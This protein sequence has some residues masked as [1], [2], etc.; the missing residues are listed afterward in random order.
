MHLSRVLMGIHD[1][2]G[3]FFGGFGTNG[4]YHNR[5][6]HHNIFIRFQIYRLINL[7]VC[8]ILD[9]SLIV[10]CEDWISDVQGSVEKH[11]FN[12]IMFDIAFSGR[13]ASERS[14]YFLYTYS[15]FVA[16]FYLWF[17]STKYH[18][19]IE[20]SPNYLFSDWSS[21][22]L[23]NSYYKEATGLSQTDLEKANVAFANQNRNART[24][25]AGARGA[26]MGG[27][28]MNYGT[29]NLKPG[30]ISKTSTVRVLQPGERLENTADTVVEGAL[31][32]PPQP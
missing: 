4:V 17:V 8:M 18:K 11:G 27:R 20:S 32:P 21:G 2:F 31:A 15:L 24:F 19:K 26:F 9:F 29:N 14:K 6:D 13:C 5:A 10:T 12:K 1:F 22:V 28:F 23:M 7:A 30:V 25:A 3:F 16:Y